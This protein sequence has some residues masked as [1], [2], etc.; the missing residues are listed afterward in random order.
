MEGRFTMS[1][2]GPGSEKGERLSQLREDMWEDISLAQLFEQGDVE[3]PVFNRKD[4]YED[5]GYTGHFR[6]QLERDD[7]DQALNYTPG[8]EVDY[9]EEVIEVEAGSDTR[10][11]EEGEAVEDVRTA[12]GLKEAV[13][14]ELTG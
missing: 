4:P 11:I 6:V 9:L 3:V 7:W 5:R 1:G 2:Y 8:F 13:F 12:E 10:V 14:D